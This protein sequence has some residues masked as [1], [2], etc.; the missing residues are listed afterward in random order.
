VIAGLGGAVRRAKS[1]S[2]GVSTLKQ[3]NTKAIIPCGG[4]SSPM[5]STE[6]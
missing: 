1:P 6:T 3:A 4:A 5:S 2:R